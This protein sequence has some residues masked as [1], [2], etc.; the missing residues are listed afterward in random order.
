MRSM[1]QKLE[2]LAWF[3][4]LHPF[5]SFIHLCFSVAT[6]R[7]EFERQL[8]IC[9]QGWKMRKITN[10][11]VFF[12]AQIT[13]FWPIDL[14][15]VLWMDFLFQISKKGRINSTIC[16]CLTQSHSIWVH[17]GVHSVLEWI[18]VKCSD[19][20]QWLPQGERGPPKESKSQWVE[21]FHIGSH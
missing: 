14:L 6:T 17:M 10:Q 8:L 19:L 20:S 2:I 16:H 12:L 7:N 3:F 18:W 9:E 5:F 15:R 1:G 4:L 13:T 21:I 11:K